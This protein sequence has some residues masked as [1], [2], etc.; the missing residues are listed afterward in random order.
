MESAQLVLTR[1]ALMS[2]VVAGPVYV[3]VSSIEVA[4]TPGFDPT[5]HA[6]SQ[7]ALS[8]WGWIHMAN[9]ILTGVLMIGFATGLSSALPSARST[10]ILV[11]AFGASFVVAGV[12]RVDPGN[13]FPPGSPDA[14]AVSASGLVH[15]IAGAVGFLA[16]T[17]ALIRIGRTIPGLGHRQ[18]GRTSCV[19]ASAFLL[20]FAFL[21]SGLAGIAAGL[22]V[23]TVAV[24]ALF[25]TI[26]VIA[27][28]LYRDAM[29]HIN[30]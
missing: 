15:F 27:S 12:C 16:I 17:V 19:V 28:C 9:L 22:V 8:D 3:G 7:L 4:T 21:A 10:S 13:G 5:K 14:T 2:G 1:L 30:K 26:T 25:T 18:L 20:A 24:I 29:A 23:F 6:W 11:A